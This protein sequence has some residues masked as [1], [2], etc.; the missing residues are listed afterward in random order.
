MNLPLNARQ[1]IVR[2]PN[3]V[4]DAVMATPFFTSLRKTFPQAEITCFC[5]PM[6]ADIFRCNDAINR[7]MELDL[8]DGRSRWKPTTVNAARLRRE[9]FDLAIALP[10]SLSSALIFFLARISERIGYRGDWRRAFLTRSVSFP[11][12]GRRPHRVECYLRLLELIS[13]TPIFDRQLEFP[14]SEEAAAE[15]AATLEKHS[16]QSAAPF[17]AVAPGAAQ[18]NKMWMPERFAQLARLL[19][20][21]GVAVLI[22][23]SPAE[24]ELADRVT[25]LSGV[26]DLTNLAGA[27]SLL[28][29][30]EIIRRSA[31]FVGNDSGLAHVAAAVGTPSVILSG[32]GDPAEVAPLSKDAVTLAKRLFCK[33]CYKNYCWR[34]DRPLECLE[35]IGVEEVHSAVMA[36]M[37]KVQ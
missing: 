7:V 29:T 33:P 13:D 22:I 37:A 1:I 5:R 17:V 9:Q 3:W 21:E 23:G 25:E 24:K 12:K 26:N 2:A 14:F 19:S 36:G 11:K 34:K 32:P 18:P 20:E 10:N 27:G 28:F 16:A 15:V 30:A 4:G 8:T 6:V 31:V 35:I